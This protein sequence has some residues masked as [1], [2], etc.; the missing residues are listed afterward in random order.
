MPLRLVVGMYAQPDS[1]HRSRSQ[2][3]GVPELLVMARQQGGRLP[4][5]GAAVVNLET[6]PASTLLPNSRV[7]F[8][9]CPGCGSRRRA[10]FWVGS[11]LA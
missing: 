4:D 9:L 6:R 8:V 2:T 3:L 5:P 7:V 1:E 11:R 10:L